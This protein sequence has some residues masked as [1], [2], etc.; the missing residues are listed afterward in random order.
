VLYALL[1]QLAGVFDTNAMT[2]GHKFG[3]IPEE[4]SIEFEFIEYL[5]VCTNSVE[6]EKN[7]NS[8]RSKMINT[9][10]KAKALNQKKKKISAT[11]RQRLLANVH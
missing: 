3:Y 11:E 9:K 5:G 4:S 2:T 8:Y 7:Y 10:Q 6:Y 1:R